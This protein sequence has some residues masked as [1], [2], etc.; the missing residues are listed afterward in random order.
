[1]Y[2]LM[3]L[4][5]RPFLLIF[6]HFCLLWKQVLL[7]D[8]EKATTCRA[9]LGSGG[10]TCKVPCLSKHPGAVLFITPCAPFPEYALQLCLY[11]HH[12][13]LKCP[14]IPAKCYIFGMWHNN[15]RVNSHQRWKQTWFRVCF[16]LWCELT[17]TMNVTEWQVPW[18]LCNIATW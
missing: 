1:M 3:L 17:S 6:P 2:S 16:H 7:F 15:A 8:V 18:N 11:H 4:I 13:P 9:C 5:E 10:I 12:K 14:T